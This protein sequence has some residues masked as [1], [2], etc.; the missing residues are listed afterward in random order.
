MHKEDEYSCEITLSLER[1][2]NEVEPK[3]PATLTV[4]PDGETEADGVY[5]SWISFMFYLSGPNEPWVRLSF[6]ETRQLRKYL[7][8]I[9]DYKDVQTVRPSS[10]LGLCITC[11]PGRGPRDLPYSD[12]KIGWC[13]GCGRVF[14]TTD[15]KPAWTRCVECD[16]VL[17]PSQDPDHVRGVCKDCSAKVPSSQKRFVPTYRHELVLFVPAAA[18]MCTAL[19]W[20]LCSAA[21]YVGVLAMFVTIAATYFACV[22][23]EKGTKRW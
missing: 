10:V 22:G 13:Q 5:R 7:N 19:A 18:S 20:Y 1:P 12:L 21:A 15:S 4:E 9:L 14:D 6:D 23:I 3:G 2:V 16:H 17:L 8:H 11:V